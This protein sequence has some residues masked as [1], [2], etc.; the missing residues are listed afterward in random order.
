MNKR[1]LLKLA[2][3]SATF[4]AVLSIARAEAAFDEAPTPV[5][6]LAPA[7]PEAMRR[8][9]VS[10][11]VSVA[12][13]VDENG[14]VTKAAVAKSTNA[15]F[16][17]PALQAVSQWKFKPAKKGGQAVAVSVVLPVRFSAQ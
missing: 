10:G 15:E 5:R 7:Y 1:S 13:T 12:V 14:N 4:F 11:M 6:T 9:G 16:E 8:D 17:Q 3:V 2:L